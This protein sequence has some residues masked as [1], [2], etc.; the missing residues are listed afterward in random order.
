[1]HFQGQIEVEHWRYLFPMCHDHGSLMRR[2]R[3]FIYLFFFFSV[4]PSAPLKE[5]QS[6]SSRLKLWGSPLPVCVSLCSSVPASGFVCR[7]SAKNKL[8]LLN[9]GVC[10]SHA[11]TVSTWPQLRAA[12][13][14]DVQQ[15]RLSL[16]WSCW[17][18]TDVATRS[19]LWTPA[20]RPDGIS[21]WRMTVVIFPLTWP[22]SERLIYSF[23]FFFSIF[24]FYS[25]VFSIFLLNTKRSLIGLLLV[26]KILDELYTYI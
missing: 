17:F 5:I 15:N 6:E 21:T 26:V 20:A 24:F 4:F 23:F 9:A 1:M 12:S 10:S 25:V 13:C 3:F 22:T 16:W 8:W 2:L 14:I 11:E 19:A 18:Q 7:S